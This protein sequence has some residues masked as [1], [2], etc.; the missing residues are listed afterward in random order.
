MYLKEFRA[1][2]KMSNL[3][4]YMKFKQMQYGL[5]AF[6]PD[7]R[8]IDEYVQDVQSPVYERFL[9]ESYLL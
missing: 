3:E 5:N 7:D 8:M 4:W 6:A 9:A 2:L 1:W